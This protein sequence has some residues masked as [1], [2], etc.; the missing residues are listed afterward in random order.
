MVRRDSC[1]VE[2][3]R[4]SRIASSRKYVV[5]RVSL[6]TAFHWATIEKGGRFVRLASICLRHTS[7]RKHDQ[8]NNVDPFPFHKNTQVVIRVGILKR[9]T[10]ICPPATSP[11]FP[12]SHAH[13]IMKHTH[14]TP[15]VL[16]KLLK[17][18]P[19]PNLAVPAL[20]NASRS[21]RSNAFDASICTRSATSS[22]A[23]VSFFTLCTPSAKLSR[24][25]S[26]PVVECVKRD[27]ALSTM[28]EC[29]VRLWR[30]AESCSVRKAG[31]TTVE[32]VL[33]WASS[34]VASLDIVVALVDRTL[35]QD[36]FASWSLE[37]LL[38][39]YVGECLNGVLS[40]LL[41]SSSSSCNFSA[42]CTFRGFGFL[43]KEAGAISSCLLLMLAL[44]HGLIGFTYSVE[45]I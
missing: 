41:T 35:S 9:I 40:H 19:T 36:A 10:V 39:C 4:T 24:C 14:I 16:A 22:T 32:V 2:Y 17:I 34:A 20:S 3:A 18:S 45:P 38:V 44:I 43:S 15:P 28:S 30:R 26:R 8:E 31:L 5:E 6:R 11:S 12:H 37:M 25:S 23:S 13:K 21:R 33:V 1:S 29:V 27:I 7:T 42:F